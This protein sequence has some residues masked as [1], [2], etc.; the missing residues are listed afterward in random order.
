[1]GITSVQQGLLG[2]NEFWKLVVVGTQGVLEPHRSLPD[3]ERIDFTISLPGTIDPVLAFQVKTTLKAKRHHRQTASVINFHSKENRLITHPR[4]WYF[5][6]VFSPELMSF[7]EPVFLV[8]SA[9][10][11][12]ISQ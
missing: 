2:E 3:D 12:G 1:M 7:Q 11:H 9:V 6:A 10:V 4:F 8:P 5:F